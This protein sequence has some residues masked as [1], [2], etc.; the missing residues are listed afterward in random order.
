[1]LSNVSNTIYNF[2]TSA[3]SYVAPAA[4]AVI[5]VASNTA[6][7]LWADPAIQKI[8]LGTTAVIFGTAGLIKSR[9][10]D[11]TLASFDG[12]NVKPV[13]VPL[14]QASAL[15]I[16]SGTIVAYIG[17]SDL[18]NRA[19]NSNNMCETRP[20]FCHDNLGITREAM[21]QIEGETA[22]K[23]LSSLEEMGVKVT[24][25]QVP[26][27]DL[28]STQNELNHQKV[29]SMVTAA[30]AGE[31]SPCTMEIMASSDG[32]VLDGHHRWATCTQLQMPMNVAVINAPIQ[33]LLDLANNFEGVFHQG[34]NQFTK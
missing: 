22:T 13:Q 16:T 34:S 9:L 32:H 8:Y 26:A 5:G 29:M 6:Q 24:H 17:L 1:M 18:Y 11:N 27:Q 10:I 2:A 4:S 23:F 30:K 7:V 25:I 14:A 15:V 31:F 28:M 21:P 3:S 20:G 12:R 33:K 19:I